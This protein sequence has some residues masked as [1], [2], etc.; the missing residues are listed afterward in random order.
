MPFQTTSQHLHTRCEYDVTGAGA[1][2]E[3]AA[4]ACPGVQRWEDNGA[5]W[6]SAGFSLDA[7]EKMAGGIFRSAWKQHSWKKIS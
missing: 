3:C 5:L 7:L 2:A 4:P 1:L 6:E